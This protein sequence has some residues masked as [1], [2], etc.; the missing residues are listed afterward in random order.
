MRLK[1]FIFWVCVVFSIISP[2]FSDDSSEFN[3]FNS[4]TIE[5]ESLLANYYLENGDY[6]QAYAEHILINKFLS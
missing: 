1:Q 4:Q 6:H 2:A 3:K 5:D